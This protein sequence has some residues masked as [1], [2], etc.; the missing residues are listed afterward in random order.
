MLGIL[1]TVVL[2]LWV[3]SLWAIGYV[4]APTL[5]AV[6]TDR[7]LAGQMAGSLF[8]TQAWVSVVCGAFLISTHALDPDRAMLRNGRLLVI[9]IMVVVAATNEWLLGSALRATRELPVVD[10]S[11]FAWLHGISAGLYLAVSLLGLYLVV[12]STAGHGG[13]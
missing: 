12:R 9:I 2:T 3:G 8:T 6:L 1:E 11:L 7:E 10:E 13:E 4:A 5:F